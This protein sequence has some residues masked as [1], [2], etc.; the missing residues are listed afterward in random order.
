M[1]S[2]KSVKKERVCF[3]IDEPTKRELEKFCKYPFDTISLLARNV[4]EEWVISKKK[5]TSK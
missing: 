2:R 3:R 1:D 4:L 5:K